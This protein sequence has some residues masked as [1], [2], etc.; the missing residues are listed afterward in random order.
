MYTPQEY[1]SRFE[2][3]FPLEK[4]IQLEAAFALMLEVTRGLTRKDGITPEWAH[5]MYVGEVS[6]ND[7][8]FKD[9]D[10]QICCILHDCP[11]TKPDII[12]PQ[13]L[14][15]YFGK[16]ISRWVFL[17]TKVNHDMDVYCG[18]LMSSREIPPIATKLCDVLVNLR[19]LAMCSED[20]QKKQIKEAHKYY[21]P[22]AR[23]LIELLP[24]GQKHLGYQIL[25]G[26]EA[27]IYSY[28]K[29]FDL[30]LV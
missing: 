22:L 27:P 8:G 20:F 14:T 17:L 18:R 25:R 6:I 16:D 19:T 9:P 26:L 21:I 4:L 30:G 3:I 2:N 15:K 10:H 29:E 7:V 24:Q 5:S 1:A 23:L 28:S 11:E 13:Y 12:T